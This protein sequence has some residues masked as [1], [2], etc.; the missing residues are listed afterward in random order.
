[1]SNYVGGQKYNAEVVKVSLVENSKGNP[2]LNI[3][4][5]IRSNEDGTE[6]PVSNRTIYAPLTQNTIP[7]RINELKHHL[8][9]SGMDFDALVE[10]TP[11][12]HDLSG[13]QFVVLCKDESYADAAG[14]TKTSQKWDFPFTGEREE[15]PVAMNAMAKINQLARNASQ[16]AGQTPATAPKKPVTRF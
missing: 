5:T 13:V 9:Y 1:M 12:Y 4:F 6:C 2:Q 3:E 8:G 7:R 15:K 10:G 16:K 11:M 14:N